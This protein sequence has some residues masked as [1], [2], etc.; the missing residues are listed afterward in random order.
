MPDIALPAAAPG[1]RSALPFRPEFTR[2]MLEPAEVRRRGSAGLTGA[3]RELIAAF[4]SAPNNCRFGHASRRAATAHHRGE[5]IAIVDV[6]RDVKA[7]PI[8]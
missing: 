6:T 2:Q 4:V 8:A 5:D 1:I 7:A 3:E